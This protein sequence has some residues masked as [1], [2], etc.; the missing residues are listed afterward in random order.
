MR[1]LSLASISIMT[2][3]DILLAADLIDVNSSALEDSSKAHSVHRIQSSNP[4]QLIGR[5]LGNFQVNFTPLQQLF[6]KNQLH[7][8]LEIGLIHPNTPMVN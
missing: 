8:L 5:D 2:A 1:P 7:L 6:A 3:C 4:F